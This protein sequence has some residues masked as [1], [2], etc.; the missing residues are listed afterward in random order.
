MNFTKPTCPHSKLEKS[1]C[2]IYSCK[3]CSSTQIISLLKK[4]NND[5][6]YKPLEYCFNYEINLIDQIKNQIKND[7]K[8]FINYKNDLQNLNNN[9]K[10]QIYDLYD[11]GSFCSDKEESGDNSYN[12]S[13]KSNNENILF[14]SLSIYYKNRKEIINHIKHLCKTFD[15]N[16]NCFYL[17]MTLIEQFFKMNE[18]GEINNYQIDLVITAIFLLAFKF[19]DSDSEY[20]ICYKSFKT[21]FYKGKKH[22]RSSDLKIAEVQCLE[23]LEYNLNL[24]TIYD[25]YQLV[26]SSGI[27]LEKETASF[28]IISKIYSECFKLLEFCFEDD[29]IMMEHSMSEIIFSIIYLVRKQNNL[30]YNI[31]KY[32]N[33]IYSIELKKYLNCIKHISSKYYKNENIHN[34]LFVLNDERKNYLFISHKDFKNEIN[35]ENEKNIDNYKTKKS[36]KLFSQKR[37]SK[38][39][40]CLV[41]EKEKNN[42]IKDYMKKTS[43]LLPKS[44]SL[45][46]HNIK[47]IQKV[48]KEKE[49]TSQNENSIFL[50]SSIVPKIKN[51]EKEII[52]FKLNSSVSS[53]NY[54]NSRYKNVSNNNS[55]ISTHNNSNNNINEIKN[56]LNKN[57]SNLS[58]RD[59]NKNESKYLYYLKDSINSNNSKNNIKDLNKVRS[60]NNI[61]ESNYYINY[62]NNNFL[63][64]NKN[65]FN[66]F[67]KSY[68][69][70]NEI[71]HKFLEND[72][73]A[74]KHFYYLKNNNKQNE[75]DKDKEGKRNI[76]KYVNKM[77]NNI[78][79]DNSIKLPLIRK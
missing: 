26:L 12:N 53:R 28:N 35:N 13:I 60:C 66:N 72:S 67:R 36:L 9:K 69:K 61:F 34:N 21:H 5:I 31:E 33:K 57:S 23:I 63:R 42:N 62:K 64:Y 74:S 22:I 11:D 15:A 17:T 50:E 78:N 45:D 55:T 40:S 70:K 16:K 56:K 4:K 18:D 48:L 3:K 2:S 27:V 73:S 79:K 25:F 7:E 30:I 20:Y 14:Q 59:I 77:Y 39:E 41:E 76:F 8:N 6:F 51:L 46:A 43:F 29:D 24:F 49:S 58:I 75:E 1:F 10:V 52:P 65:S 54:I 37:E 44:K 71:K 19:I 32:F 68:D 47:E 38:I